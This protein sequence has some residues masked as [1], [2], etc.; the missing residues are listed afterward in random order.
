MTVLETERRKMMK[1]DLVRMRRS[2]VCLFIDDI[3]MTCGI[4]AAMEAK[5]DIESRVMVPKGIKPPQNRVLE[6]EGCW[7]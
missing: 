4:Q 6:E 1:R 2:V 5:E 7:M 3:A